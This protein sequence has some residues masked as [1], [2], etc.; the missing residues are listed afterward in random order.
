MNASTTRQLFSQFCH[1][2][3]SAHL[4]ALTFCCVQIHTQVRRKR[5][6]IKVAREGNDAQYPCSGWRDLLLG[7]TMNT[8]RWKGWNMGLVPTCQPL[9]DARGYEG[10]IG[11]TPMVQL[12]S[13]SAATGCEI[14]V[15]VR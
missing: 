2:S 5:R 12:Q 15:K 1:S 8:T 9:R 7:R 11:N 10:L 3:L 6:G 13:L 14:L 4:P